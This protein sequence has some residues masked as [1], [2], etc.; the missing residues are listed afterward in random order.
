MAVHNDP[1][2]ER[3][4][5]SAVLTP[6][7][8]LG[9]NGFVI[10]MLAVAGVSFIAGIVFIAA[11]AWPVMGF[12]GL[13]AAL[14]YLAFRASYRSA[15]AYEHVIVTPTELILRKVSVSGAVRQW[16]LNPLWV[17]L[18]RDSDEHYGLQRLTLVSHGRLLPIAGCLAPAER[19][20]FA[21]AFSAA[22][23]EA[24][25]GPTRTVAG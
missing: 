8:S 1:D 6:H 14:I 24:R 16:T 20:S 23:G 19:D 15:A 13:D 17:R 10:L 11:G 22:L 9:A 2:S 3:P 5:F 25:R 4:I 12:F 21:A 18:E 7:R